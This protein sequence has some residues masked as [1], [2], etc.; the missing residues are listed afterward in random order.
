MTHSHARQTRNALTLAALA[1][2]TWLAVATPGQAYV[3]P[4]VMTYTIQALA[5]VAVA[6]SAVLGVAWRR[7]RKV[8]LHLLGIDENA[9]KVVEP[10]VVSSPTSDQNHNEVISSARTKAEMERS[11][12]GKSRSQN[13]PWRS[14]IVLA[15]FAGVTFCLINFVGAPLEIVATNA[16]SLSFSPANV[17]IP[18]AIFGA[19]IAV[20][21]ALICSLLR[22]RAFEIVLSI[23]LGVSLASLVEALFLN[24]M[25]PL[26]DGQ[27]VA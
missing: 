12:Q 13:L 4:S 8:I 25:L 14:R 7:A 20:L 17:W 21:M 6:L 18:L 24:G 11:S 1:A 26:A 23:I 5:G 3:D 9:G 19:I 27:S 10:A 16:A 22:G 2:C 15:L